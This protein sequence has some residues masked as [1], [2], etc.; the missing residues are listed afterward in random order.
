MP[1]H[2]TGVLLAVFDAHLWLGVNLAVEFLQLLL[3][4]DFLE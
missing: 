3:F 4:L 2:V 1:G